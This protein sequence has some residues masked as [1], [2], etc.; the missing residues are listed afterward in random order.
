MALNLSIILVLVV[1][2][3]KDEH[4]SENIKKIEATMI[5]INFIAVLMTNLKV[6]FQIELELSLFVILVPFLVLGVMQL[7]LF[8]IKFLLENINKW[9]TPALRIRYCQ[10]IQLWVR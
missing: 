3:L 7:H 4:Q 2:L 9:S 1:F 5:A 8:G 6:F 10:T